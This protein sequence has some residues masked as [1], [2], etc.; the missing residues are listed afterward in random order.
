MGGVH[1]CYYSRKDNSSSKDTQTAVH[2]LRLGKTLPAFSDRPTSAPLEPGSP[3][4]WNNPAPRLLEPDLGKQ[5]PRLGECLWCLATSVFGL[6]TPK[7]LTASVPTPR[8]KGGNI[9]TARR[10]KCK[11][12]PQYVSLQPSQSTAVATTH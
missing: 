7:P 8:H 10:P 4:L 9:P 11:L 3:A 6:A 12:R 2:F 5:K 1:S